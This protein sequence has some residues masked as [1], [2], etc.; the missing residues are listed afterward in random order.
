MVRQRLDPI[1]GDVNRGNAT[2]TD[3]G[4]FLQCADVM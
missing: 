3:P 2:W 4:P 1:F